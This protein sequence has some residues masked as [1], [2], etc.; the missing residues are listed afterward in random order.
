MIAPQAPL[1][2]NTDIARMLE[3]GDVMLSVMMPCTCWDRAKVGS[4]P[5]FEKSHLHQQVGRE[6]MIMQD[7]A[8]LSIFVKLKHYMAKRRGVDDLFFFAFSKFCL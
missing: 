6:K 7:W 2:W 3:I 5:D 8:F 4:P 1:D